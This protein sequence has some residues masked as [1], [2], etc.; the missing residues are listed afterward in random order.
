[1]DQELLIVSE[2]ETLVVESDDLEIAEVA[3][4]GPPGPQGIPG[5]TGGATTVTVGV[6]AISGHA[7]VA[8]DATGELIYA[9]C[10]NPAHI[11]A[12]LGVTENAYAAGADAEVKTA[13]TL[14]HAGWAFAPGPVYVGAAGALTQSLPPGAVFAQVIGTAL[15]ST[16]L[17]INPQPPIYLS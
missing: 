14:T 17:H 9:D 10:T 1:M 11:G 2:T 12:V 13:F 7:A 6:S 15:S 16:V 3:E 5:P 4:Q 8:L